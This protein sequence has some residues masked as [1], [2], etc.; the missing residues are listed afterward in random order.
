MASNSIIELDVGGQLFKTSY[1]TL[2]KY[3]NSK[4][5]SMFCHSPWQP[6][7]V[8]ETEKGHF[9]LDVNPIHFGVV[10]DWLRLGKVTSQ[11]PDLLIGAKALAEYFGLKKLT[12]ELKMIDGKDKNKLP[13]PARSARSFYDEQGRQGLLNFLRSP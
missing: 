9:F 3:P 5:F 1:Q 12:E 7:T 4:L 11:D 6:C 10:L 2:G 13:S 8:P